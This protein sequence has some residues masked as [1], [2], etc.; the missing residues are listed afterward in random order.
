M[1][2]RFSVL[3][4]FFYNVFRFLS[5]FRF[6]LILCSL[7]SFPTF[8]ANFANKSFELTALNL[9]ILERGA[10][11]NEWDMRNKFAAISFV[12]WTINDVSPS[13]P[14][15]Q[16]Y[17]KSPNISKSKPNLRSL[18]LRM[19]TRWKLILMLFL[20][21]FSQ[22]RQTAKQK[23]PV[24]FFYIKPCTPCIFMSPSILVYSFVFNPIR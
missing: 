1:L 11:K 10:L 4:A 14:N 5:C 17:P 16:K 23:I 15:F 12:E 19:R 7:W 18:K 8:Y 24:P 9:L 20:V 3:L 13:F 21:L 6:L 2:H 22:S